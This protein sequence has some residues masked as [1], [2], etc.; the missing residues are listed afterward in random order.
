MGTVRG[1]AVRIGFV[2]LAAGL[3]AGLSACTTTEGTSA[4][5]DPQTFER[6]V[7]TGTLQ[8]LGLLGRPP[9]EGDV[10]NRGPLVVP[11]DTSTLPPPAERVAGQIPED[12]ANVS[13]NLTGLSAAEVEQLR[14]IRVADLATPSGRPLSDSELAQLRSRLSEA[15]ISVQAS[16]RRPLYMPPEEY[17]TVI[18]GRD[19][20]CLASNGNLV[21]IDDPS[22]PPEVRAALLAR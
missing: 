11:R 13:V 17:F 20:V 21:P 22:C 1:T 19:Y 16:G 6:E 2:V 9:V 4:F 15:G 12:S 5:S 3:A 18:G 7:M 14:N 10:Q 8:G